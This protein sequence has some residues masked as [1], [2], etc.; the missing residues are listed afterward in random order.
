MNVKPISK[1]QTTQTAHDILLER[2]RQDKDRYQESFKKEMLGRTVM[3]VYNN[4]TYKVGDV[5]FSAKPTD[6]FMVREEETSFVQYYQ[7]QYNITIH[8][9]K[10]P[11]LI[12]LASAKDIR[13]GKPERIL[14]VPELCVITGIND[15]MRKNFYIMKAIAEK[16]NLEPS[17]HVRRVT[18]LPQTILNNQSCVE[19]LRNWGVNLSP[20]PVEVVGRVLANE[21]IFL[22]N[23]A[24]YVAKHG[25]WTDALNPLRSN[26]QF[27]SSAKLTRWALIYKKSDEKIARN[28]IGI[29]K[30]SVKKLGFLIDDPA[31]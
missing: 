6:T 16:T 30:Q 8:D 2:F 13:A 1:I 12:S 7:K 27:F 23:E 9:K 10:Q 19:I 21:K 31:L 15:D 28:F 29:L 17:V 24:A 22:K 20:N 25:D 14:L 26:H 3:T 5:D 4:R 18:S 11:M